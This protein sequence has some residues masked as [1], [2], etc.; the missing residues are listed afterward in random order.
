MLTR[1]ATG[2]AGNVLYGWFGAAHI[3]AVLGD[4]LGLHKARVQSVDRPA[5][6]YASFWQKTRSR[7]RWT[8][9]ALV[10]LNQCAPAASSSR[11]SSSKRAS[12]F[13]KQCLS[14]RPEGPLALHNRPRPVDGAS[15]QATAART[16]VGGDETANLKWDRTGQGRFCSIQQARSRDTPLC[17]PLPVLRYFGIGGRRRPVFRW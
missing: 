12:K 8:W 13:A 16:G 7:T 2:A 5:K 15:K 9:P 10:A 3:T 4:F 14:A 17:L 11:N 1:I 6:Q